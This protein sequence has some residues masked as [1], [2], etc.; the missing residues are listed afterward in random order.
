MPELP[1]V[2]TIKIG[3][4]H[5]LPGQ[6]VSSVTFDSPKSFPNSPS[7]VKHFLIG[8]KVLLVKRRAKVLLIELS[9]KYSLAIHL[10]MTGQLV[11]INHMT[12]SKSKL[13]TIK[14]TERFGAGHPN[15][16]LIGKLPDK[17]TRVNIRFESGANLYFNDQ[18]KFGWMKLLPTAEIPNTDF[19]KKLGPE[20]LA[21]SFTAS[22]FADRMN[23]RPNTSIK[24]AL[25]DQSVIAGVGNIYSDESLWGAKIHPATLVRKL[26]ASKLETL[27]HELQYVLKLSINKGGSTDKNY[28]DA[29][30]RRGSYLRFARVFRR[31]GKPCPRCGVIIIKIRI[32]GRGTHICP[33]CQ[34]EPRT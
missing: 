9:S 5:L 27:F 18:R 33:H 7:D 20:P 32:A 1:E 3:L 10:K 16:S 19:F 34:K 15:N 31:D 2:E 26:S 29:Q 25:L 23:K 21:T 8:A 22:D 24:A 28:L 12:K 11:F 6:V 17:S 13:K 30:G 14:T 4:K